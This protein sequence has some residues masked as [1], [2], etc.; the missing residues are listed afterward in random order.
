MKTEKKN[1]IE[2]ESESGNS[3]KNG[4]HYPPEMRYHPLLD[5]WVI[6]APGRR[7]RPSDQK[8]SRLPLTGEC[9][10]CLGNESLTPP[11]IAVVPE[12][13]LDQR[14]PWRVRVVPNKYPALQPGFQKEEITTSGDRGLF[15]RR[16][17]TGIHEV[18][19]ETPVHNAD[20]T[21]LDPGHMADVLRTW[22]SRIFAAYQTSEAA[23]ALIFKNYRSRAGAS[24]SHPHSQLI[25]TPVVPKNVR[26]KIEASKSYFDKTGSCLICAL[27]EEER[28]S[29][30]RIIH[31]DQRFVL[32]AP[33]AS[34]FPYEV[35]IVPVVHNWDFSTIEEEDIRGLSLN[36]RDILLR[37][38]GH[39]DDP[40]YNLVLNTS[41][42]LSGLS[43]EWVADR[44]ERF[45][46]WHIEIIPR[47]SKV[48]GFEWG[49]GF[50]INSVLPEEAARQLRDFQGV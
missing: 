31:E 11:E 24:L 44:L 28:K 45:T 33:Y 47:L 36:L 23:Y 21:T 25:A 7:G 41:P 3:G 43:E 18:I 27:L 16:G 35:W 30:L 17:G 9:P 14:K 15:I 37:L 13:K 12:R 2:N 20:L 5:R 42:N 48:A 1:G 26:Q 50:H 10:F 29:K 22:A 49:S 39:L 34:R 6:L 19:V 8:E 4:N 38:K 32:L 40:P 46:H